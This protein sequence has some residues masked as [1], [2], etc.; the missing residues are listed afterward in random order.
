VPQEIREF[1]TPRALAIWFMDDGS[2]HNTFGAKLATQGFTKEECLF[3]K[4]LLT[5]LYNLKVSIN[6]TGTVNQYSLYI[7]KE[8]MPKFHK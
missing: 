3:L 8:S 6:K 7:W 4:D 5:E 1:L 2:L